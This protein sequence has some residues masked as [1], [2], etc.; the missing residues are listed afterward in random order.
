M[1]LNDINCCFFSLGSVI[2]EHK[3][4]AQRVI[5][6]ASNDCCV[7]KLKPARGPVRRGVPNIAVFEIYDDVAQ[8]QTASGK[9]SRC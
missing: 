4:A 1:K 2:F 3:K 5:L 9:C 8:I 7:D 6:A